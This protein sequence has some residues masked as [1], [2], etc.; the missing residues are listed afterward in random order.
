MNMYDDFRGRYPQSSQGVYSTAQICLNGHVINSMVEK[1]P[2][3]NKQFCN[4]CGEKTII[5]C[6]KCNAKIKGSY[7]LPRVVNFSPYEKSAFCDSCGTA[8]PWTQRTQ[9]AVNE[10]IEFSEKLN[11]E[12]KADF[13]QSV[14]DLIT[15]T[16]KTKVAAVKFKAYAQKVGKEIA[17]GIKEIIIDVVSETVKKSIWGG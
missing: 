5:S 9:E 2:E 17:G 3:S 8:Y 1:Y 16:P 13:K 6:P 4:E 11:Q 7:E 15:E 14:K 12:E 10:L